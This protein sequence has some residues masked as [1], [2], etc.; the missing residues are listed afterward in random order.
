MVVFAF[1]KSLPH[2]TAKPMPCVGQVLVPAT[3]GR[4]SFPRKIYHSITKTSQTPMLHAFNRAIDSFQTDLSITFSGQSITFLEESI[5][6]L[7]VSI[8]K[9]GSWNDCHNKFGCNIVPAVSA[10][11]K[12]R[13]SEFLPMKLWVSQA[14]TPSFTQRNF[15]KLPI[16]LIF[17]SQQTFS[18]HRP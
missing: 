18:S 1:R 16:S 17:L 15:L 5:T 4:K 3:L 7:G 6:S 10:S 8:P 2:R 9:N 14:E 13:N 12:D 11:F